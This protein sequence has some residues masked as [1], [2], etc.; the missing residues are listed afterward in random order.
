[1]NPVFP[2]RYTADVSEP[3]VV[4]LIGFRVNRFWAMKK[5]LP[6]AQAMGPMIKTLS[7]HPEK[8][9][10]GVENFGR[11]W[12][13]ETCMI[14]YWRSFEDLTRFACDKD[15]PHW[16]AWQDFM[17]KIGTDGSVGI[18]HET[19]RIDPASYECIYGNMPAFGLGA[20]TAH[21]SVSEKTQTARSRMTSAS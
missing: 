18:W 8:G 4:F 21:I 13:L 9:L 6:V 16:A 14:S 1:M 10:L 7:Q 15:D 12:P 5:W 19:Y 11:I 3:F 20:A 17:R 2:G